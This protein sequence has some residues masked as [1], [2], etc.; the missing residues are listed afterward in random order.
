MKIFS[1]IFCA[2][3]M[4]GCQSPEAINLKSTFEDS[5]GNKETCEAFA[6]GVVVGVRESYEKCKSN[7]IEQR[8]KLISETG[9]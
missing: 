9:S 3:V 6:Y 1:C 4:T 5:Q 8:Y 2:I 7:L